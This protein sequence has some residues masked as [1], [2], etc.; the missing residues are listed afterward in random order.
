MRKSLVAAIAL[1]ALILQA[2]TLAQARGNDDLASF[3]LIGS[4]PQSSFD[5]DLACAAET[6]ASDVQCATVRNAF[7]AWANARQIKLRS[8]G[9]D[10]P[11]L[12]GK[13][14]PAQAAPAAA[15]RVA[16]LFEPVVVPA[17]HN[18]SGTFNTM[19]NSYT[20]GSVG[21][22]ATAFFYDANSGALARKLKLHDRKQLPD[23]ANVTPAMKSEIQGVIAKLDPAYSP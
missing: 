8:I 9:K 17:M 14:I 1:T 20:P 13:S 4:H 23:S 10:D 12:D 5:V 18:W 6:A 19:A 22:R 11:E 15:Y 7:E 2:N 3:Q 21:Y 16:I